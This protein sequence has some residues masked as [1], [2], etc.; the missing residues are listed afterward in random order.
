MLAHNKQNEAD[1]NSLFG[2]PKRIEEMKCVVDHAEDEDP[3]ANNVRVLI[4]VMIRTLTRS[5]RNHPV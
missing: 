2:D 5:R 1:A 4:G 3:S